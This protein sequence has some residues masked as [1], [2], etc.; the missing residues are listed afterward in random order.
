MKRYV[1]E[2][3]KKDLLKKMVFL[4]GPRQVGKTTLGLSLL[5]EKGG[6]MNW[7]TDEGRVAILDKEFAETDLLVFDELH[8]FRKWRN[9]LK[10]LYDSLNRSHKILVTGSAK[11]DWYRFGGDS[12]QGRYFLYRLHPLSVA[13]LGISTAEDFQQL[14][15]LGGFPEPFF[16]GSL[17]EARRWAKLYRTRLVRED[18]ASLEDLKDLGSIELLASRLPD[19]VGSPLSINALREDLQVAHQTV[20]KWLMILERCFGLFRLSPFGAAKL[21]AVKKE[22]KHYHFDWSLVKDKGARFEN[23][24]ACHLLKWCQLEEDVKGQE[25]ELRYFRDVSGRE[26][27]FVIVL[28][29]KPIIAIE[30]KY[31]DSSISPSLK[32]FKA[33][34]PDCEALQL[35]ALA[36]REYT[37]GDGIKVQWA[38]RYLSTLA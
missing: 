32:Y 2:N 20:A 16:S 37:S 5:S 27:D 30:A 34:F 14:L 36:G 29:N 8:K 4:S 18:I 17:A 3:I 13:E 9:Y 7:D 19:L 21:K 26:V 12:L 1:V 33:R 38:P 6:Y 31:E 11:L 25:I 22:Q 23:L 10:G 24:L 28:D 35:T 15:Q